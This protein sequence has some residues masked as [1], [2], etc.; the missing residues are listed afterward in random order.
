M[1]RKTFDRLIKDRNNKIV[2]I[3]VNKGKEYSS[4]SDVL[5]NFNRTAQIAN[6]TPERALWGMMLKHFTSVS[7]MVDKIDKHIPPTQY[8]VDEKIGDLINYLILLEALMIERIENN[9][10]ENLV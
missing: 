6:S 2:E 3:L 8:L 4:P 5:H 7:D 1:D 9:K 10:P